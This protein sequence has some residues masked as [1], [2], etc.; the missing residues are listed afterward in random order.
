MLI[1]LKKNDGVRKTLNDIKSRGP[2]PQP[3]PSFTQ[4]TNIPSVS[5]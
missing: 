4:K 5:L 2:P 3:P 1:F